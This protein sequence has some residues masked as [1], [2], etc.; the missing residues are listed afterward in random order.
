MCSARQKQTTRRQGEVSSQG[1]PSRLTAFS[2]Q[3]R[4]LF[5]DPSYSRA[6]FN[7]VFFLSL[8]LYSLAASMQK[9]GGEAWTEHTMAVGYIYI[10]TCAWCKKF[11]GELLGTFNVSYL[12]GLQIDKMEPVTK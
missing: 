5:P 3:S 9:G 2:L 6:T 7:I 4:L 1:N 12:L 11:H 8:A 10:L